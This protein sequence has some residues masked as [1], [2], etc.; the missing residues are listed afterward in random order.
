M[1][2]RAF[3]YFAYPAQITGDKVWNAVTG[4]SPAA[5]DA[6]TSA[7]TLNTMSTQAVGT[8][9]TGLT[10]V[11]SVGWLDAFVGFIE[12]SMGETS[13]LAIAIGAAILIA[14]GVGSWRII[15]GCLVGFL[16]FDT[17]LW[18]IGGNGLQYLGLAG[19]DGPLPGS[20]AYPMYN[21]P[22]WWHLVVGGFAFG[23]V[24]MATDPVSSTWT[25]QGHWYYGILIGVVTILIRVVNP[26][27]PAGIMLAVLFGNV[28]APLIDHFVVQGNIKRRLARTESF[29]AN[30]GDA[31]EDSTTEL[32]AR[33]AAAQTAPM[34]A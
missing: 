25:K 14:V 32:G 30:R 34:P 8:D 15:A 31:D 7:T 27:Y 2:S 24:F 5:F 12:G 10:A 28:F 29:L 4:T 18:L 13:F 17:A 11:T 1:T 3:L 9:M 22:P 19:G 26:A 23:A 16:V 33:S 20:E 6:Y 21:I